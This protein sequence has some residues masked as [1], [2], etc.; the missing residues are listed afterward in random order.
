VTPTIDAM[1]VYR[2]RVNVERIALIAIS[3]SLY[4]AAITVTAPIPTP[5]GVGHF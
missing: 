4:A 1:D 5:W 2:G 3:A